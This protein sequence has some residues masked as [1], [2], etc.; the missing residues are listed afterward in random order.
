VR[1]LEHKSYEET[2][3]ELKLFSWQKRRLRGGFVALYNYLKGSCGKVGVSLF[4]HVT[5][6]RT[7]GNGLKLCQRRFRLD[8]WKTFSKG[9]VRCWNRL[10][11]EGVES[12]PLQ[13]FKKHLDVVLRDMV[14]CLANTLG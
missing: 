1:G 10:P 2:L 3:R 12:P 14:I 7:R 5:S 6:N 11:R 4:S 13:V 8:I 9:V